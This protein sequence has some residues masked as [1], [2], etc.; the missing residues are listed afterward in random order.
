M[1]EDDGVRW[2][3]TSVGGFSTTQ[4]TMVVNA[5]R[6]GDTESEA[7]FA[8]LCQA[9]W[10]PVYAFIRKGG[11]SPEDAKD[12]TQGF[13]A[14]IFESRS[15]KGAD[16][17]KG[18]FRSYLLGGV[19]F[20]V[21]RDWQKQSAQKRGGG[22]AH[23]SMDV[24]ELEGFLASQLRDDV[25]PDKLFERQWVRTLLD[26]VTEELRGEHVRR[27]KGDLFEDL[28]PFLSG[29]REGEPYAVIAERYGMGEASVK[30]AVNRMRKR[31]REILRDRVADTV[32][33]E[34]EIEPELRY[35][36]GAFG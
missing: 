14:S 29:A 31:Y 12:L 6:E 10:S 19:K 2:A 17:E 22:I 27:D 35:L 32:A 33:T 7:A 1:A 20:F 3:D 18:K 11:K 25:S 26:S 28:R 23:L 16:P 36:Q 9:Y 34:E 30:M 15:F 4:W 5:G 13:F 24:E 8:R 21:A